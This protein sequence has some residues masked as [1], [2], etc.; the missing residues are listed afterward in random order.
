MEKVSSYASE[1]V[2]N[3][4][5]GDEIVEQ[6]TRDKAREMKASGD[7]YFVMH[8]KAVKRLTPLGAQPTLIQKV[9]GWEIL[10]QM[11]N[12][13]LNRGRCGQGVANYPIPFVFEGHIK[14]MRVYDVNRFDVKPA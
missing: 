12:T 5:H 8:G 2:V 7:Y 13:A 10:P 4:Y 11:R 6:V 3:V 14:P 1:A 9:L